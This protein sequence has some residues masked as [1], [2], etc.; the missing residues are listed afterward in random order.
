M[1]KTILSLLLFSI[2]FFLAESQNHKIDSLQHVVDRN[3]G[4]KKAEA[5]YEISFNYVNK[6]DSLA[7]QYIDQAIRE[8]DNNEK[9]LGISD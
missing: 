2:I 3:S 6:N 4:N 7:L 1:K 5:L 9:L 8:V